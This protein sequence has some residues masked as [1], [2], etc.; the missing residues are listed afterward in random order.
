MNAGSY[1]RVMV[2]HTRL[3]LK[4]QRMKKACSGNPHSKECKIAWDRFTDYRDKYVLTI[5]QEFAEEIPW[6][7]S[8]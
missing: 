4:H 5:Q 1:N 7:T 3:Q 6:D 2:L 8:K